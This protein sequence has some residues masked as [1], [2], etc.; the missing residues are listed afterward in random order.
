[1]YFKHNGMSSTQIIT[2]S[3]ARDV[4]QY[5]NSKSKVLKCCANIYFSQQCL[6]QNLTSN[7]TK[8]KI[9]NT[10]PA[11]TLTKHKIV[12]LRIKD[13]IKYLHMK[14]E[15]LNNALYKVHLKATQEWGKTWYP[16]E[17][18]VNKSLNK[19]LECKYKT[20]DNKFKANSR[21][22]ITYYIVVSDGVHIKFHLIN[23]L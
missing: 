19:E 20:M 4:K 17:K 10:T 3:Q 15:K 6:K 23:V 18:S 5:N 1:M 7:Y 2:A 13:E 8:I 11:A 21:I 12:K 16:I 14:K 9:P 22:T